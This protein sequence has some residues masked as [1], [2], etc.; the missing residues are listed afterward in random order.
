MY[1]QGLKQDLLDFAAAMALSWSITLKFKS[2]R[3]VKGL[4]VITHVDA[5]FLDRAIVILFYVHA[6][7]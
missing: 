1:C 3:Q 7:V 6:F 2:L 4:L 5:S